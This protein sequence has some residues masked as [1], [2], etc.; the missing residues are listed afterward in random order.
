MSLKRRGPE[1][2]GT[3]QQGWLAFIILY[4]AHLSRLGRGDRDISSPSIHVSASWPA[5][6]D[7]VA[8]YIYV[9]Y[10]TC[11]HVMFLVILQNRRL[12]TR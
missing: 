9:E 1:T 5:Y 2:K 7:C 4:S 12:W 10:K 11:Q 3:P 8:A 6:V